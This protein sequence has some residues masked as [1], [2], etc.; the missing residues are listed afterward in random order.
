MWGEETSAF[1]VN[2]GCFK[3]KELFICQGSQMNVFCLFVWLFFLFCVLFCFETECHTVTRLECSGAISAYCNLCLLGSINSPASASRIAGITGMHHHA[4]LIFV[5]LEEMGFH[6]VGQN[7]LSL[8]TSWSARPCL[9]KCWDYRCEPL[10]LDKT[11]SLYE[12]SRVVRLIETESRMVSSGAWEEKGN[13][14][15]MGVEFQFYKMKKFWRLL[16]P[17]CED[18]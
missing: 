4:Q 2:R 6:H 17:Q 16:A 11:D 13:C 18:I 7:G 8:L 3:E 14:G 12:V 1:D 10:H 15:L 9:P 5:F